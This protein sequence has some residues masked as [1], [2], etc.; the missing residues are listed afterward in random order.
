MDA[1]SLLKR[2]D[3][4]FVIHASSLPAVLKESKREYQVLEIDGKRIMNY[5]SLYFD[6]P[7]FKF[8]YD[9]HN[10]RANRIK[11]RQR[12]YVD[13][14]LTFLEIKKKNGK[15]ETNKTRIKIDDFEKELSTSSK[16]FIEQITEQKLTLQP[17][18][19]NNFHR[20]TLVNLTD[21][22]RVT[23]DLGLSYTI[24]KKESNYKKIV[25][26]EVK[27]SEFNRTSSIIQTL[28]KY[29]YNP[30]SISKYCVG[31][32]NLYDNEKYN[33][34]KKKLLKLKKMTT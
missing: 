24:N 26:V 11:I 20:I 14:N 17:R 27:Q 2:T 6:T 9:H 12:K 22:E 32:V 29:N 13:S 4:K 28:K 34:F 25:I 23:I 18:L 1:V 30:Y 31:I 16:E 10:Q 21:N 3:T 33:L 15:G 5:S 19:W 7:K 8:Y